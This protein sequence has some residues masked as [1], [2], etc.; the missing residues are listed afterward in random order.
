MA[1]K[2]EVEAKVVVTSGRKTKNENTTGNKEAVANAKHIAKSMDDASNSAERLKKSVL[3][4]FNKSAI[5]GW[6]KIIKDTINGMIKATEKQAAYIENLNMMQVAFGK[7]ADAATNYIDKLVDATG[8]DA[9][10]LTRQ[11]GVFRQISSAMGYTS[12]V[13]D[14]LSTNLSKMS[15]DISSLFN[16]SV[17]RAGKS[18]ESAITGQVRSIRSLTGA[19]I[20]LATLQQEAYRLG[21]EKTTREMSRAEKTILI[22]LSLERQLSNANHDLSR[23]INSVANQTKVF[24]EQIITLGRNIGGFLIPLLKGLLPILNGILMAINAILVTIQKLFGIDAKTLST[25][26]GLASGGLDDLEESLNGVESA[27]KEAKKQL[28]GFDKLNNL[29]TPSTSGSSSGIGGGIGAIDP[30]LLEA[31]KEYDLGNVESQAAKIR[32]TIMEWLGFTKIID[33]DTEEIRWLYEGIANIDL[34]SLIESWKNFKD[35]VGEFVESNILPMLRWFYE[36]VL[37]PLA[38]Y[39]INE[40]LP[41]FFDLMSAAIEAFGKIIEVAKPYLKWLWDNVLVPFGK[42]VEM[43]I[44]K[45]IEDLTKAIKKFSDWAKDNQEIVT[46]ITDVIVTFLGAL[47]TYYVGGKVIKFITELTIA[48]G[49]NGLAKAFGVLTNPLFLTIAGFSLLVGGIYELS[50]VWDKMTPLEKAQV[51][52]N[53]LA[54][55]ALAAALAIGVFHASWS[56]GVAAAT[57]AAGVVVVTTAMNKVKKIAEDYKTNTARALEGG[58]RADGGF[59][60]SGDIFVA[61]ENG[62]P[63]YIGSFGNQTAVANTDQ[64]V[65]GIAIG[66]TKAMLAVNNGKENKVVIEAK[67]DTSGLLDFITFEQKKKDRQYGL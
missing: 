11:L 67:G 1:E 27:A 59:V 62:N 38:E 23:T 25:E 52:L 55:A 43:A 44:I 16:T 37:I 32:D 6:A 56:V 36:Q 54:G 49:A 20:T 5:V 47:V 41:K 40:L 7:S 10:G 64:I 61:N 13:A 14:L 57:I 46:T 60:N 22:Y 42:I 18:L 65:D 33:E 39:T 48:F 4:A 21:I 51:I 19:D 24:K 53:A 30:R 34:T 35:V 9:S 31:L 58:A 15:L 28:R 63:E 12:E 3:T 45:I 2:M 26:F 29:T 50:K 8:F 17:E 66:V